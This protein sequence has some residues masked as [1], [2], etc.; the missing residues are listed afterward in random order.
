MPGTGAAAAPKAAMDEQDTA[1]SAERENDEDIETR[2]MTDQLKVKM[3]LG[4]LKK[5]DGRECC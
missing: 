5:I 3:R 2:I 4:M 1:A